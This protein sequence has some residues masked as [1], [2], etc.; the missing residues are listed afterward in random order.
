MHKILS[1]DAESNCQIWSN[2][3]IY[4]A[5]V[6]RHL[7]N[8]IVTGRMAAKCTCTRFA[9]VALTN[10]GAIFYRKSTLNTPIWGFPRVY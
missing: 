4:I 9:V 2:Q 5:G 8:T 7:N 10:H 3:A 1:L 6:S